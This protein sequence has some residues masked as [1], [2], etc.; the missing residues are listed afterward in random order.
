MAG[1][2]N[3]EGEGVEMKKK[4][5]ERL[6]PLGKQCELIVHIERENKG[7]RG[8]MKTAPFCLAFP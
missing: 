4:G 2:R 7:K 1:R 5:R 8:V 3:E 6:T